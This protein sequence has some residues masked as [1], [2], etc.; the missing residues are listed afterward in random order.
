MS[1]RR[2]GR[3]CDD[4]NYLDDL[5]LDVWAPVR[6]QVLGITSSVARSSECIGRMTSTLGS[7]REEG[8]GAAQGTFT[9]KFPEVRRGEGLL[10][11]RALMMMPLR[12]R[13][14]MDLQYTWA[15]IDGFDFPIKLRAELM[16]LSIAGYCIDVNVMKG[17]LR[18]FMAGFDNP[19][20]SMAAAGVCV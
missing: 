7:I 12:Y 2:R 18:G 4:Q 8:E 10:V 9:Q 5:C 13:G 6:R 19:A 16:H 1:K 11:H 3:R 14:V 17:F 20:K 15:G